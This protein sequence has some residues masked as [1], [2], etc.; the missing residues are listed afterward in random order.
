MC[1]KVIYLISFV[2]VLVLAGNASADTLQWDNGGNG[3]LWSVPENWDPNGVPTIDD[4]AQL[5]LSGDANNCVIDSS[6]AAE[7]ATVF[8]GRG[9][10]GPCY[11]EMTGGSLTVNGNFQIGQASDSNG[12]FIMSGG[13]AT[14]T[15]GRLWIG[16]NGTGTFIMK[17]GELNIYEKVEV[18]KNGSGNGTVYMEGGTMNLTGSST[19]L[20]IGSYGTG[21]MYMTGG[22]INLQDNIKLSQGNTS[23]TTGV[24]RLYLYGGTINA[25]NL[26]NPADGIY[27]SPLMDIT[28]GLL[29]LP[30]DYREIVNE[31][32][33]RGWITAYD[34]IGIVDVN[35]APDPNQTT[36]TGRMPDPE[37]AWNPN[38]RNRAS[39]ELG[40]TLD[41][42]PGIYASAHD[43]YFGTDFNDVNDASLD[44]P[45]GVLVSSAQQEVTYN[46]GPLDLGQ[47]YYWRV[48]EVNDLDPN[49]PW[50]GPVW[51]F[52]VVDYVVVDDFES[53]ND[54]PAGD[55][56]SHLIYY[57]WTDGYADPSAN[58]A[59]IGY[60][61][62]D[63]LE[64]N[65]VHG[66]EKAAPLAYDNSTAPYSEATV[67]PGDLA[68]GKDW[69]IDNLQ[70]LS[71]W[72]YGGIF[73]A[74]TERMYVKINGVKVAYP[75]ALTDVQQ[76]NWQQWNTNLADFV[77]VDLSNVTEFGIGFE[78]TETFGGRGTIIIDDIRLYVNRE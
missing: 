77:G 19:D 41:W 48:D 74:Y 67:N 17:G 45:L 33:S 39:V 63:S 64:T 44:N 8:V 28:E 73:N 5:Y 78:K 34:G 2:L 70:V 11:L 46:P 69:T 27:G 68:V 71:L 75:G 24:G 22:V 60:L 50:K 36:V 38:P 3:S 66:G 35:Y 51:Q 20:E 23:T 59:V 29:T 62:G 7:C 55:P 49:S 43:I 30:G 42:K 54:I 31:Y 61:V 52:T 21:A 14:S 65:I 26:R 57:T 13:T 6:V 4:T 10:E 58:G 56:G 1:E 53:Y 16:M 25:G 12:V 40:I 76:P 37:L 72:F 32:I 9:G 18:G 47:T 15:N